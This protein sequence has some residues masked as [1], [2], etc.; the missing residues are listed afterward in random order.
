MFT[1]E[2]QR[3]LVDLLEQKRRLSNGELEKALRVSPATLR[4]DLAELEAE[5]KL[6][7]FHGGAAHPAYLTGEPSLEEKSQSSRA[8][9]QAIAAAAAALVEPRATIF[10]DAGTTCLEIGRALIGRQDLTIIANSIAFAQLAREGAARVICLGGEVRGVTAALVGPLALAWV[11]QLNASL[12]FIGASGLGADGPSTTELSEAAIKQEMIA[13]AR[14][15]VLV[16]DAAKWAAPSVVRVAAWPAFS[17]FVTD[18]RLPRAAADEISRLG[19]RVVRAVVPSAE[20]S[21]E[22]RKKR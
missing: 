18:A 2:R 1:A 5:R 12:A 16:A 20:P 19:P 4:R 22:K 21:S 13:R 7:R 3:A 17:H 8:E 15:A 9:K 11:S 10:L 14:T 6:I